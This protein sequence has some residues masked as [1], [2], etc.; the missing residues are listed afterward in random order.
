MT[1]SEKN[2]IPDWR[3]LMGKDDCAE[4]WKLVIN[5]QG[6]K[7]VRN[8]NRRITSKLPAGSGFKSAENSETRIMSNPIATM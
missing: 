6:K 2:R 8:A 1:L 7:I 3:I 4:D 5:V